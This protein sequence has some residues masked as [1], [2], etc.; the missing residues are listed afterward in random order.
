MLDHVVDN[1][2]DI[3]NPWSPIHQIADEDGLATCRVGK[4]GPA[5]KGWFLHAYA[6]D[7]SEPQQQFFQFVAATMH[8]ADNV[9]RA[10]VVRAVVPERNPL[11]HGGFT[12][13][14]AFEHENVPEAFTLE[15]L[16]RPSQL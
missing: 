8:I 15:P 3:Q 5:A 11:N 7:V 12:F 10:V 16:E 2:H 13:L 9:E 1:A 4:D 14:D 6:S